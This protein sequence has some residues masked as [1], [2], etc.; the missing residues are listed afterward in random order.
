MIMKQENK[1]SLSRRQFLVMTASAGAGLTL[2][3]LL[4]GCSREEPAQS[5]A[6]PGKAGGEMMA[7][8]NF[9]PNAFVRIGADDRVT[10]TI[11]HLEMGQGTYTGLATLVAEE[12]D[13]AWSQIDVEGAQADANTYN[14][15]FWGKMQGTGGSTAI[16]NSYEQMR[17][18]GAAA[19]EMLVT[20][21]AKKWN[22]EAS[23]ITVQDGVLRNPGSGHQASFGEL[24]EL[25]AQQVVP[26]EVFLKDPKEFRLIGTRLPRKDSKAK[27]NGTAMF[28]QDVKLPGML[29]ALVAHPP[30]FGAKVK[31]FDASKAKTIAGVDAIVEIPNGVAVLGK[32]FWSA[33]KGRDALQI[34]W[35][36]SGAFALGSD[37]LLAEYKVLANKPG[38]VARKDGDVSN[39]MQS[40]S[41]TLQATL[42]FP[43]LAHATLEPMNCVMQ[44][45]KDGVEIWN[46]DQFQTGD[47]N[48]VASVFGIA[49][50]QVKINMLYAGG[51]FGRRANPQSDYLVETATIVKAL[52]D[53]APV[54]LVWTREDDMRAGY[55]RP[56]Y[57][58]KLEAGLDADGN[59]V[60][61]QHRIVGQS[62]IAGTA[63]EGGLVKDGID[64]TSVEGA[65][66]MPY[67]IPNVTVELHTT[68]LPVPVQWW[69]S[70]GSTHTAFAVETFID[71]LAL[72]ANKDPL[73][74][75]RALLKDHPRQ[76]GVLELVAEK[77]GWGQ[78]MAAG[79]GRGIAVHESFNSYVAQVAEVS[80]HAN[81]GFSVD[82]VVIAVDC[83]IA[84][85]PDIVVAQMEGGM[86]FGLSATLSSELAIDK[87]RVVQSNFHDYTVLRM[88]QMPLVEVHIVK[89][90]K[91][92]TG[93]GEPATPV[94][95]PAVANALTAATGQRFDRLPLR[96]SA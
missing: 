6:G 16:A 40:A 26:E 64:I 88:N 4:P 44:R 82:R 14:N 11:K 51:S 73:E 70:V 31:S 67:A 3:M 59:P 58:H 35:D 38:T 61:W 85:N 2:G 41:S 94:I 39:A 62:I 78:P 89:S 34:D 81:K 28:T 48:A 42:E 36:E 5:Q 47:Q 55:Y 92:P 60:A 21:A 46:G 72:V 17:K 9:E 74:F 90:A 7:A 93:V 43:F 27:T 24:A 19:R 29:T 50:E 45:H 86:G 30:R 49:P 15:L 83:G 79:R 71:Q 22:V 63:F 8:T 69:R 25:A 66:N 1:V 23:D 76:L 68:K 75:R 53:E 77:A 91:P 32:D 95:A 13:A 56:L 65:S 10:V 87:G 37:E 12:L 80:V 96:L 54:K 84:I 52:D 20:A 57:V 18:A 33:K